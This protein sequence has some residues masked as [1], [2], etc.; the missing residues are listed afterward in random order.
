MSHDGRDRGFPGCMARSDAQPISG[1]SASGATMPGARKALSLKGLRVMRRWRRRA[2]RHRS[3][4]RNRSPRGPRKGD[5]AVEGVVTDRAPRI[6]SRSA[7]A[8]PK[9]P[10]LHAARSG[11]DLRCSSS[12]HPHFARNALH[13][14]L[15]Q[16]FLS[17]LPAPLRSSASRACARHARIRL[18][19]GGRAASGRDRP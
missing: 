6:A 14:R 4:A 19:C 15:T 13:R 9:G 12:H 11:Y 10:L 5:Q 3:G 1:I 18:R 17:P 7:V 8:S 16:R 2:P